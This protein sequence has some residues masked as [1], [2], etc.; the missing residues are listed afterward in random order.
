MF[1]LRR[2]V[3]SLSL[4]VLIPLLFGSRGLDEWMGVV[5]QISDEK[6]REFLINR[7]AGP[8]NQNNR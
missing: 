5:S 1:L 2:S 3:K 8:E 6:E 7:S 4:G